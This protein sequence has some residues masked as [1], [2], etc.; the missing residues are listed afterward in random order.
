MDDDQ[1]IQESLEKLK[2]AYEQFVFEVEVAQ[3]EHGER[4][5]EIIRRVETRKIEKLREEIKSS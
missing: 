5:N 2:S 4:I 1:K 3:R